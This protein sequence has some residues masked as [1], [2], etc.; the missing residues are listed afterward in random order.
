MR[1]LSLHAAAFR[2]LES[3]ELEPHRRLTVL[4][5]PNGAGKTNVLEA[6][7]FAAT[8]RPLRV[9]ERAADLVR[10]GQERGLVRARFDERGPLDV[11]VEL[12]P[13]GRRATVAG[14]VVKD[15]AEIAERLGVVSFVPD[16][17]GLVRQGPAARRRALD[18]FAFSL[19]PSF[20]LLA[21]RFEAALAQRNRL[22]KS[23]VVD[24]EL[25][26]ARA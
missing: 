21:R 14:K 22:F 1:L 6:V 20:A 9:V 4:V 15:A 12:S 10:A 16:D 8:L 26:V 19:D 18:R 7:H 25:L 23:A 11:A 3:V 2:N 5:G 13:L 17:L 24:E